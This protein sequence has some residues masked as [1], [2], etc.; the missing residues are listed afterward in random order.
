[1]TNR[2][3]IF[4][5]FLFKIYAYT[6]ILVV[7][8]TCPVLLRSQYTTV[9]S[10]NEELLLAGSRAQVRARFHNINIKHG[11][12]ANATNEATDVAPII[13]HGRHETED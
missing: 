5:C 12:H 11:G 8:K 4:T 10:F 9:T 2:A 3:S 6:R 7:I 13:N 1:M